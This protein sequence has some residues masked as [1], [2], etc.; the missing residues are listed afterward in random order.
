MSFVKFG[1]HFQ[2]CTIFSGEIR[3][4]KFNTSVPSEDLLSRDELHTNADVPLGPCGIE[5]AKRFQVYL[6]EYQINI[7][8]KEYNN[9]I[10]YSG[11]DKDK[12]IYLYMHNNHY[13]VITKMPG[14]FARAYYRHECKKANNNLETHLCPNTCKCCGSRPICPDLSWMPCNDCGRMFKSQ[15]CYDQHKE[16]R[17]K[18]DPC[19]RVGSNAPNARK[20]FDGVVRHP[21]ST[22]AERISAGSVVNLSSSMAT[23]VLYLTSNKFK[24]CKTRLPGLSVI[25]ITRLNLKKLGLKN[26]LPGYAPVTFNHSFYRSLISS[27]K[28]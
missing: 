19:V 10:I 12:R 3:R 17:G 21:R 24:F 18:L 8:S 14:F 7:V 2:R 23:T 26:S 27:E 13:D 20:P 22:I 25:R 1:I 11:P 15:Q 4:S 5:E 9:K 6:T 16:P 28:P